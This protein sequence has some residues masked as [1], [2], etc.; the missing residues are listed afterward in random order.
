[1]EPALVDPAAPAPVDPSAPVD[2]LAPVDPSAPVDPA[3]PVDPIAPVVP[4]PFVCQIAGRFPH[5]SDKTKYYLCIPSKN[6]FVQRLATCPRGEEF[7][8]KDR[9]CED[10]DDNSSL[11]KNSTEEDDSDDED[12]FRCVRAGK[13]AH[14]KNNRK[15]YECKWKRNQLKADEKE[16]KKNERFDP[17]EQDC[18]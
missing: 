12:D 9:E 18:D 8:L 14:P 17:I 15:Y 4:K 5:E 2:P 1:M 7:D 10:I 3:T 16:C 6:H 11:S 13:F